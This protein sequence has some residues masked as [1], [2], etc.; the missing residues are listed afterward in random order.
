MSGRKKFRSISLA[1]SLALSGV[2]AAALT[3]PAW[4]QQPSA[5]SA[6]QQILMPR[7][8]PGATLEKYLEQLRN[9]FFQ[10]DADVDG[11]IT[12]RDV[13]LH[14]LME[15]IQ[16]RTNGLMTTM[17]YDLD[18]DGFVTED[19]IRR[20]MTYEMRSQF[21][22][23]AYNKSAKPLLAPNDGLSKQIDNLVRNIM[24]L[25]AD[26]DGKVSMAE[27]AKFGAPGRNGGQSARTRQFLAWRTRRT[28]C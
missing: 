24:A 16:V 7:L 12:Q 21:G 13:D 1:S 14:A 17:R 18:G 3:G 2:A 6:V 10:V 19:E 26:K 25:D 5:A 4:S 8:H 23:L 9:E 11:Q 15:G 27:G 22:L 28:A 20:G